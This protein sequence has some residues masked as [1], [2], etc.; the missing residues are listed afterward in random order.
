MCYLFQ[1][2]NVWEHCTAQILLLHEDTCLLSRSRNYG[3]RI[4]KPY[5]LAHHVADPVLQL[6]QQRQFLIHVAFSVF[7]SQLQILSSVLDE[8]LLCRALA[9]DPDLNPK[10]WGHPGLLMLRRGTSAPVRLHFT[11]H[12][13]FTAFLS[14]FL[15]SHRLSAVKTHYKFANFTPFHCLSRALDLKMAFSFN[16]VCRSGLSRS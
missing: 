11:L 2:R 16:W 13:F 15:T 14:S 7:N 4:T 9:T 8:Q 10:G 12:T 5:L 6:S 3:S 1:F